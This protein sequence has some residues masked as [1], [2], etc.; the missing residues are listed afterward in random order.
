[1]D[2]KHT[3]LGALS[4]CAVRPKAMQALSATSFYNLCQNE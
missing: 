4:D 1:M 2:E 3:P